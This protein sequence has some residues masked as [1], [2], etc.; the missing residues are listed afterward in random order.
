MTGDFMSPF[1]ETTNIAENYT[2]TL[3]NIKLSLPVMYKS[4]I[5]IVCDLA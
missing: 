1:V 5:K 4:I 2:K 3:K